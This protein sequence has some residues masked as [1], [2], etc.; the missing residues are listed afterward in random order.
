MANNIKK[1]QDKIR[2]GDAI[3]R[4]KKRRQSIDGDIN[5]LERTFKAMDDPHNPHDLDSYWFGD[6][7][8]IVKRVLADNK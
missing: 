1:S 6:S 3:D 4:L 5:I 7:G 8:D 2:I